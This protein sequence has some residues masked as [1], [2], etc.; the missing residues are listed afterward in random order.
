MMKRVPSVSEFHSNL[1][2]RPAEAFLAV[3]ALAVSLGPDVIEQPVGSTVTYLR[4]DKPFVHVQQVRSRLHVSFPPGIPLDDP[5]GRLLR[6][7]DER[8]VTVDGPEHVDGHVQEF[9]RK[10]YAQLRS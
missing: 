4:R 2:P 1:K 9:V 5:N 8:Y 10:A 3:R 6:R 7:G